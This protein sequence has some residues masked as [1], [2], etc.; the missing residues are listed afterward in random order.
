MALA[1]LELFLETSLEKIMSKCDCCGNDF[2]MTWTDTH[3]IAACCHCGLPYKILH[4][5]GEGEDLK[6]IEKPPEICLKE[7]GLEIAK[8]YWEKFKMRVFPGQYDMGFLRRRGGRTYSGASESEINS[9]HK[10]YAKRVKNMV[11]DKT[12]SL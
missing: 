12:S 5:E 7:G 1:L 3:G 2:V 10:W 9:F 4:Y 6:R 11:Q 8:E